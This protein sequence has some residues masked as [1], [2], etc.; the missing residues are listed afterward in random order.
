V[1]CADRVHGTLEQNQP[2]KIQ[3]VTVLGTDATIKWAQEAD[4]L[5]L[6]LPYG[7]PAANSY[8]A[9]AKIALS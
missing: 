9:A 6:Q 4:A 2:G 7:L 8:G 5:H 1:A 3:N